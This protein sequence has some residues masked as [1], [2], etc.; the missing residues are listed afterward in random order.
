LADPRTGEARFAKA[1]YCNRAD[2]RA[3]WAWDTII[4]KAKTKTSIGF[5]PSNENQMTR[6][7]AIDFDAHNGEYE[8]ARTLSLAA[9]QLLLKHPQLY[10]VL[11][12]SG[13]G[14]FHLFIFTPE[15]YP[16]RDWIVLLK[17]VCQWIGAE[18][19]DGCCEIFPNERAESQPVGKGIRAPGTFNPKT[20]DCSLIEAETITPLLGFLPR[21]WFGGVGKVNCRFHRNGRELSLHKSINTYSLSTEALIERV[22][23]QHPI[24]HKGTR[25]AVLMELTG[26]LAY[27][28]GFQKARQIVEAHY[29]AYS[30]NI[31]TPLHE[32]LK[33]FDKAWQGQ[34]E[35]I[36]DRFTPEE[37]AIY[38]DLG[39][40][41]QREAFRIV[42]A[43]AGAA[44]LKREDEFPVARDSLAD[45][46]S[47]TP[48]G[49]SHVIHVL[50]EA[51]AIRRTRPYQ[52]Q[53]RPAYYEWICRESA[54]V[55]ALPNG[56]QH[57]DE[58]GKQSRARTLDDLE[59]L[60][61]HAGDPF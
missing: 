23:Q 5:Y 58:G 9:F 44:A 16:V 21:T 24:L 33:Q 56:Q 43:F 47:I 46:L 19:A 54:S 37:Q 39:T 60:S 10:L 22:I 40:E 45:R 35:K 32:H 7:G 55:V 26:N 2:K 38:D 52:P 6:W 50:V 29:Q 42:W 57:D 17:Q 8:R 27:K 31:G 25:N 11:C 12:T 14:G 48:V 30:S 13:G 49:A 20:G 3:S 34:S 53:K 28:F 18:I 4:G 36:R 61:Y 41:H 59:H 51:G 1:P 15:L